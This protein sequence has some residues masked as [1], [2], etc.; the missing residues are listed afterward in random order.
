M[1]FLCLPLNSLNWRKKN[2][3]HRAELRTNKS[4][5][6]CIEWCVTYVVNRS[7]LAGFSVSESWNNFPE[8]EISSG[9]FLQS[10]SVTDVTL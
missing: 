8:L 3:K 2:H 1:V 4:E 9:K 6:E 7:A 5:N 10:T